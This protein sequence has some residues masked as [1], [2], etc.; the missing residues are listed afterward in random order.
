MGR[1]N[2]I[3]ERKFKGKTGKRSR[4]MIEKSKKQKQNKNTLLAL[5]QR[6][7]SGASCVK[8]EQGV[9]HVHLDGRPQLL[10]TTH[11]R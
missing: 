9:Y 6:G 7:K 8:V 10:R 11:E 2:S 3:H 1:L 5:K 4:R